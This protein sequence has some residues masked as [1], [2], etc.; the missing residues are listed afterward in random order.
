MF[1]KEQ[2]F[3]SLA[4]GLNFPKPQ[5]GSYIGV[6]NAF[7]LSKSDAIFRTFPFWKFYSV[8]QCPKNMGL[9]HLSEAQLR[10]LPICRYFFGYLVWIVN[11]SFRILPIIGIIRSL[12]ILIFQLRYPGTVEV[13]ILGFVLSS[14]T[15]KYESSMVV[16]LRP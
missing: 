9:P 8:E 7:W 2:V 1:R 6:S 16:T 5:L 12:V 3:F 13:R 14:L 10:K 15:S 11:T 4:L